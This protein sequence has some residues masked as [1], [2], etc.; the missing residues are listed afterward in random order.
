[1]KYGLGMHQDGGFPFQLSL[2]N[3]STKPIPAVDFSKRY[4]QALEMS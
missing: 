4:K 2:T 1:M 3:N